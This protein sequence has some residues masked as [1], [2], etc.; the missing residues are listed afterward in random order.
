MNRSG[1]CVSQIAMTGR[2]LS[3]QTTV[4][5]GRERRHTE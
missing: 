2:P 1:G 5:S 4:T 3:V